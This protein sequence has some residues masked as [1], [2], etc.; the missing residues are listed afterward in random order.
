M[1][2]F[3]VAFG[4]KCVFALHMSA[5]DPKRT[6]SAPSSE[7]VFAV[8]MTSLEPRGDSETAQFITLA[9]GAAA[10]WPFAARAQNSKRRIGFLM[11]SW[12][13]DDPDSK[14]RIAAFIE[15]LQQLDWT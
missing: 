2:A 6:S 12:A 14:V 7:L 8:T 13:E 10:L 3:S 5:F 15:G 11:S 9:G 4:G 1:N